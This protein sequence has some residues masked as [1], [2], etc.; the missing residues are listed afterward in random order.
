MTKPAHTN[1][2]NSQSGVVVSGEVV[3]GDDAE[4]KN[5]HCIQAP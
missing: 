1:T 2:D 5:R 4:N 3:V